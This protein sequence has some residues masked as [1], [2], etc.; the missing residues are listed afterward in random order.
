MPLEELGQLSMWVN[1]QLGN[2]KVQ[3]ELFLDGD[4]SNSYDSKDLQD[5]R[6]RSISKSWSDLGMS[7]SQWNELDGFDL[8]FEKY[9]EKSVPIGHLEEL[10]RRL[11]GREVVRIYITV[12]KDPKVPETTA[13]IDYVRIGDDIVSF[14]PL[15]DEDIK[16]GPKSATPGGQITYTI[17]YGNNQLQP[18]DLVVREEY[19][20]RTVFI[21][22]YPLPDAGSNNIWTFQDLPP[23][24]HGQIKI[25][26]RT[27]K[28]AAK[29]DINGEVRGM[30]FAS[31]RGKI[32]TDF[33]SYTVTNNVQ[34]SS[35]EFSFTDSVT[36]KI[37]PIVGST[38]VFGEH[39]SGTYQAEEQLDYNSVS[40]TAK[41]NVLASSSPAHLNL[42][43]RSITLRGS[44][45]AGLRAEND[46][47]DLRWSDEYSQASLLNLSYKT[48]LG[49]TLSYLETS[50]QVTGIADR[51]TEWPGG[52]TDQ[53]L[54]GNFTLEGK[55]RWMRTSARVSPPSKDELDCCMLIGEP[56]VLEGI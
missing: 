23:G 37:K 13:F 43:R 27:V 39:G 41:R 4:G 3:L 6:V 33:E 19:D 52:F 10:R 42:S 49:K 50:A 2:G 55:A 48:S 16:E 7:H 51:S 36:T 46:Y 54:A 44:W 21:D 35:G 29:A 14:E 17:T 8:D 15:E 11:N 24:A 1:P 34:I 22:S 31:T 9:G 38:L 18:V 5:A 56:S 53:R 30:G 47:R 45:A 12:N 20:S 28:P 25:I 26:M 32:S 40:I